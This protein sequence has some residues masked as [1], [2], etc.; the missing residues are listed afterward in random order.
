MWKGKIVIN[1]VI[2]WD[3]NESF[4]L[5]VLP[6][7]MDFQ[8]HRVE[9]YQKYI[10]LH[11]FWQITGYNQLLFSSR[12]SVHSNK[13]SG[14]PEIFTGELKGIFRNLRKTTITSRTSWGRSKLSKISHREWPFQNVWNFDASL[15]PGVWIMGTGELNSV[16]AGGWGV[17]EYS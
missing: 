14:V 10:A 15:H 8:L 11:H 6:T 7:E 9:G 12:G 16:E 5:F 13:N 17:G 4:L 3:S 1:T 2:T